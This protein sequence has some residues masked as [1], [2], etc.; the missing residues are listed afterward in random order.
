MDITIRHCEPGDVAAV[1]RIATSPR[2]A[3][4]TLG[5]PFQPARWGG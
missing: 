5:L 3:E 1:H 2:I 4:S